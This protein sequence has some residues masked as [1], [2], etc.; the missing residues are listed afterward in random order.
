MLRM[1]RFS[2]SSGGSSA[3]TFFTAIEHV[4]E[5]G[6]FHRDL[7]L[8]NVM[9]D[10]EGHGRLIDFDLARLREEKGARQSMRTVSPYPP[11]F[12]VEPTTKAGNFIGYMAVH[13]SRA[14]PRTGQDLRG[15]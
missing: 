1:V 10:A 15:F 6:V 8:G 4:H 13:L 9:I 5:Q 2:N 3:L 14:A 12:S 11:S 7:S